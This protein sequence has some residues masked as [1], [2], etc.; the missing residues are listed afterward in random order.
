[1]LFEISLFFGLF[2]ILDRAIT[3]AKWLNPY[4]AV[5]AIHNAGIVF[6]TTPDLYHTITDFHHI[7]HYD[8]NWLAAQLCFALHLYHI[9]FY[10]QKFRMDDW[11][12]HG[13]MIGLA[14]PLTCI[15]PNYTF[16]G[17]GL[18]FTT[19]LPGGIDY[20][21][22]FLVRNG[23]L[24]KHVEKRINSFMNVWIR[25]PGCSAVTALSFAACFSTP[26]S[27]QVPLLSAL[28]IYWNGQYFM[29]QVVEDYVVSPV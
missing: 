17:C 14:L 22:L 5:H 10:W 29:R 18:F 25:S 2:T 11:L 27:N 3:K 26:N 1:M 13:M 16:L 12:H 19:G 8:T 7:E 20:S 4:Y 9:A 6:L 21:L 24:A 15:F 28:L 23:Y